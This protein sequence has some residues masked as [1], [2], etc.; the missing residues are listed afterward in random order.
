MMTHFCESGNHFGEHIF[1]SATHIPGLVN[2]YI[3]ME[4]HIFYWVIQLFLWQI[5]IAI[6]VKLPEGNQSCTLISLMIIKHMF[7]FW[8]CPTRVAQKHR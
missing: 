3:T 5:S 2:C 1:L 8:R 7:F 6:Y 4:N